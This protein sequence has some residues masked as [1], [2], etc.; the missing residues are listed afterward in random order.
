MA[1]VLLEQDAPKQSQ[2]VQKPKGQGRKQMSKV[3][4]VNSEFSI[5]KN[6]EI[7]INSRPQI[8]E[9]KTTEQSALRAAGWSIEIS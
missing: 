1:K 7:C 2:E 4:L 5:R 9:I 8:P 3:R 6:Y